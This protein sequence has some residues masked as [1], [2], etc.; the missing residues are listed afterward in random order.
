MKI[1]SKFKD[2]YDHIAHIYG[3][4]DPMITYPRGKFEPPVV[5]ITDDIRQIMYR[6]NFDINS[7]RKYRYIIVAGKLYTL[8][9]DMEGVGKDRHLGEYK[10][11]NAENY[12]E[13]FNKK[14]KSR[15]FWW[16][17]SPDESLYIGY[18]NPAFTQ[19]AK[20]IKE[21]VYEIMLITRDSVF[22]S[23][24][25]PILSDTPIPSVLSAEQAYQDIAYYISNVM[26]ESPDVRMPDISTDKEKVLQ[27]GFDAKQSFRHR[28]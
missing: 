22:V 19:I 17:R 23:E 28:K 9:S 15:R 27:H 14:E 13:I 16:S 1:I 18:E 20:D 10:L 24:L 4:G 6:L 7:E 3:G 8:R 12:P 5:N 11:F 2:Y 25:V 21:P 26:K